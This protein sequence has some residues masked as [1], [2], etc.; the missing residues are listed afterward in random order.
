MKNDFIFKRSDKHGIFNYSDLAKYGKRLP[1]ID[2]TIFD[3]K[4]GQAV[5]KMSMVAFA[6]KFA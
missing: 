5:G 1:D 3:T 4:T 6:E 2:I